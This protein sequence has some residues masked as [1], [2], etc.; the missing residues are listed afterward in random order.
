MPGDLE[1]SV[2]WIGGAFPDHDSPER[3]EALA[4]LFWIWS[5]NMARRADAARARRSTHTPE[6]V[7][8]GDVG[9]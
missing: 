2:L 1:G 5:R 4:F 7:Y 9:P 6:T 3:W 8:G